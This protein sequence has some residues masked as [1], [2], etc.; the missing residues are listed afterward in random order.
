MSVQYDANK[1]F[2][3]SVRIIQMIECSTC[4]QEVQLY[5]ACHQGF[6]KLKV[7]VSMKC[8]VHDL[9]DMGSNPIQAELEVCIIPV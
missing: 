2:Q 6:D 9:A 3:T 5:F 8:A 4:Q 7:K 1:I